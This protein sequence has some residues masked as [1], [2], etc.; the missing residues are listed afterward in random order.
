MTKFR[1]MLL[2]GA[3]C[4]AMAGNPASARDTDVGTPREETLIVDMLNGRVANPT[5]MNPF[6]EGVTISQGLHQLVLGQLWDIDTTTG[7]QFPDMAATM[8]E[9]L[10]GTFTRFRFKI[11]DTLAWSDGVPFTANDV[12]FTAHMLMANAKL[13][14]S[15]YL[16]GLIKDIRAPDA[17]TVEIDTIAPNPK[18]AFTLGSTIYGNNFRIVPEHIWKDVDAASFN[19]YPP[20]GIGPYK[21]KSADPNGYWFLWEKREDWQKTDAGAVKGEPKPRYVL[22]RSYGSEE[23]RVIAMAQ[24]DMDILTD[25]TPESLDIL[26]ARNKNVR[27]WFDHFPWADLDD[28]CERGIHFN[29][30]RPPYDKWQVRWALALATNLQKVSMAT[31]SGMM[32]ASPLGSPPTTLEMKTFHKPMA[33]W[34]ATFTLPDGYKPFDADYAPRLA[35]SLRADG[36]DDIPADADAARALF[37]VGWWK[38]DTAEAQKLLESVGYKKNGPMWSLPDGTPWRMT[39]NAPADF[40]IESQRLAFAVANEWRAFGIDANVQQMQAGPFFTVYATGEFDAG[41][42]WSSS[43]AIGPDLFVRLEA[44]HQKYVRPTGTPASFNRE[45]LSDPDV[46]AAIDRISALPSDDPHIVGESTDLL[47]ALVKQLP[48]I[49]MFGTSKFVPVN[50]YYWDHYPTAD[51]YYEGPW[52]WWS[53]F[54]FMI[55][56]FRTT[57]R[58]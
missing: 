25:V 4:L 56:S 14:L 17:S 11:R 53:N 37:G 5:Q 16:K 57:G 58:K 6:L 39:I 38:F 55:P 23:K 42:Y 24:N 52:W 21:L 29:V 35:A 8:P 13:P 31:F 1:A 26:R 36:V 32:R 9:A 3:V 18:L 54:K 46:S 15:G 20:I 50:T 41:S 22:F 45:R 34:L 44:W 43:C 40:E 2:A 47:K 10:D 28:P 12:V 33:P 30:G 27:A 19:N 48:A 51:N 49:E 7:K